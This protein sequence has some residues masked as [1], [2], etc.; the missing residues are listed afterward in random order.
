MVKM[1]YNKLVRDKIPEIIR[2]NGDIPITHIASEEEYKQ[3][4]KEKLQE[5]VTEFIENPNKEELSDI[6]EIIY[7][8]CHTLKIDK[9]ELEKFRKE[10]ADKKGT[11][12]ERI[13]LDETK[14]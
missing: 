5:E 4:L 8:L 3:K 2:K 6:L 1:K 11:F 9:I 14:N 13:I 10:K 7:S 12:K